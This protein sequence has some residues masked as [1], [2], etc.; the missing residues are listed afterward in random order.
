LE[1]QIPAVILRQVPDEIASRALG[2]VSVSLMAS[3]CSTVK[4][5][6]IWHVFLPFS[7][8]MMN[9]K[10]VPPANARFS[11]VTSSLPSL[12]DKGANIGRR[13]FQRIP[14][15]FPYGNIPPLLRR[16]SAQLLPIG[17]INPPG[18]RF[19]KEY[20]RSGT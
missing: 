19:P 12:A 10:P 7:S 14:Q 20:S 16:F 17:N 1:G 9:R 8:S 11:C 6:P 18:A 15:N 5:F 13:I 3:V 4:T 2:G